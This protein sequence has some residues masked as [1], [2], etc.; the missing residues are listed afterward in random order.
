LH[1]G[2]VP[3]Q[4][5][6]F[7]LQQKKIIDL[8]SATYGAIQIDAIN[9]LVADMQPKL[10]PYQQLKKAQY[11]RRQIDN[12]QDCFAEYFAIVLRGTGWRSHY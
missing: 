10:K 3:P 5:Q 9:T 7:H 1:Y 11:Q 4:Q 6:G 8:A 12:N 2:R